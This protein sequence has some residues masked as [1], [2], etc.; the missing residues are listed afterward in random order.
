ME[1]FVSIFTTSSLPRAKVF[2]FLTG[3]TTS[4]IR[5]ATRLTRMALQ[6]RQVRENGGGDH[7]LHHLLIHLLHQ[8]HLME[9]L[10]THKKLGVLIII[11]FRNITWK[12]ARMPTCLNQGRG[13]GWSHLRFN[14][15]LH[16]QQTQCRQLFHHHCQAVL[17]VV[18]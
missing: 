13:R 18:L 11:I 9:D 4:T 5:E 17:S 8:Q 7:L 6:S 16:H 12:I 15:H 3:A 1:L 10:H 2:I 14:H